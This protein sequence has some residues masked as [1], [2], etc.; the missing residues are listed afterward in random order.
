MNTYVANRRNLQR[1]KYET[2]RAD[3]N[4]TF[5]VTSMAQA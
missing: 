2:K 5:L 4:K 1:Y 3:Q